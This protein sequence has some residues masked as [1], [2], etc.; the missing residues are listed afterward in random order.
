M[1]LV[2]SPEKRRGAGSSA[3]K[4]GK[5]KDKQTNKR[6]SIMQAPQKIKTSLSIYSSLAEPFFN[7]QR[8]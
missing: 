8:L 2:S 5:K 3:D 6:P 7:N 1:S 4:E